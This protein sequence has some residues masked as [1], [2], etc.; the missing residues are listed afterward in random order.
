MKP[1]IIARWR[2]WL[3]QE[4]SE[5]ELGAFFAEHPE[6]AEDPA[7]W[8]ETFR[9]AREQAPPLSADFTQRVM[10]QLK[11][12]APPKVLPLRRRAWSRWALASGL[13]AAAALSLIWYRSDRRA[14]QFPGAEIRESASADGETLYYVR[15]TLEGEGVKDVA[16][17]GDFNQWTPVA[18]LP[19]A[20]KKGLF[21]VELPLSSGVYNYSFVVDGQKWIAD[22]GAVKLVDDGFGERN[23]VLRLGS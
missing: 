7:N 20:E 8:I 3:G 11:L 21:T 17:A 18:L 9:R 2:E 13:A 23:S 1:E 15:F 5:A 6:A 12:E 22:E 10:S 19:S 16:L 4:F 14:F